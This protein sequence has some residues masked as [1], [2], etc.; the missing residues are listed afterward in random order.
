MSK[1]TREQKAR[2]LVRGGWV[3]DLYVAEYGATAWVVGDHA[4]YR[5]TI[6]DSGYYNCGCK[7]GQCHPNSTDRCSHALA[8][9]LAVEEEET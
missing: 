7:Y 1:E 4:G 8:V 2:R 9:A 6:L 3:C 5:C